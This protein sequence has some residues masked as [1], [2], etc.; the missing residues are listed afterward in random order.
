MRISVDGDA[1]SPLAG[2]TI[3]VTGTLKNYSREAINATIQKHG[4][5]ASG[6]VSKKTDFVLAGEEAGSKLDKAK[7][8]GVQVI[9]EEEFEKLITS[10]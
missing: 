1:V 2:K 5:R 9:S 4:G 7:Q 10:S 8:L 3:V 6:S